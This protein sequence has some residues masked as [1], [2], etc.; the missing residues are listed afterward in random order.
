MPLPTIDDQVTQAAVRRMIS[1]LEADAALAGLYAAGGIRPYPGNVAGQEA[2]IAYLF[3]AKMLPSFA[4]TVAHRH[5]PTLALALRLATP[6]GADFP[7]HWNYLV[8]LT[9]LFADAIYHK[10]SDPTPGGAA[11]GGRIWHDLTF[12]EGGAT[13]DREPEQFAEA[14]ILFTCHVQHKNRPRG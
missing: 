11:G 12:V 10:R 4:S 7:A 2:A 3:P 8:N 1:L 14:L 13:F 6:K 5:D 9:D